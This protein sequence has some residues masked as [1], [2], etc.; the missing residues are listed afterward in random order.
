MIAIMSGVIEALW[1]GQAGERTLAA[2]EVLFRAGDPVRWLYWIE[3]G[4]MRLVRPLPHGADLVIHRAKAGTIL[5]EASLFAAT[6]HC[7]AVASCSTR[8]KGVLVERITEA[9]ERDPGMARA[10]ARHLALEVQAARARAEITSLKT[11]RARLEAWLALNG[12]ELPP[13]GK[14]R[15]VAAE[16]SVTPEALYREFAERRR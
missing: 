4:A 14:W 15:D 11:V 3:A 13:R 8:L 12:G 1:N 2:G 16:I 5:A 6:Y 10:F 9:L 7:D